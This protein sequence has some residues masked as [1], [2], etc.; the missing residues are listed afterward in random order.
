MRFSPF[1]S[2]YSLSLSLLKRPIN[3]KEKFI[4][5]NTV[6]IS[7]KKK[8]GGEVRSTNNKSK[9]AILES[10]TALKPTYNRPFSTFD[11]NTFEK[12]CRYH[13]KERPRISKTAKFETNQDT[14]SQSHKHFSH[15]TNVCKFSQLCRAISS[16]P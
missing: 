14:A 13:W 9:H 3:F 16:P 2:H 12:L 6:K 15:H 8:T 10:Q 4:R 11:M 1:M 7:Q 5:N